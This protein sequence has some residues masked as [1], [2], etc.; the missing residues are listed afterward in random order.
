MRRR[1]ATLLLGVVLASTAPSCVEDDDTSYRVAYYLLPDPYSKLVVEVD[2]VEGVEME[3]EV[4]E[5]LVEVLEGL[6][7]K[8]DG[9]EVVIDQE[10]SAGMSGGV[11]SKEELFELGDETFDLDVDSDTVRMH[12]LLLDG[13]QSDSDVLGMSWAHRHVALFKDRLLGA[14][15]TG[16]GGKSL[17]SKACQSA[18][19]GVLGHEIGH[20]IGLVNNGV[21]M[22]VDHEDPD[23][24]FHT[25]D[26]DCLMYWTYE[27][28]GVVGKIQDEVDAGVPAEEALGFCEPSLNDLAAFRGDS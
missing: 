16:K 17:S 1:H 2:L 28:S 25:D 9:I 6:V 27:R 8:P 10:L 21:E 3:E 24:P 20:T 4:R 14:C 12:V 5:L 13:R 18:E 15:T 22:V 26:P 19:L 11:W 7:D 23:H